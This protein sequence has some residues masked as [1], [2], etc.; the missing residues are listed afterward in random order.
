MQQQHV[1]HMPA[2][3]IRPIIHPGHEPRQDDELAAV[4]V[5]ISS[6]SSYDILFSSVP[7]MAGEG[8]RV[9]AYAASPDSLAHIAAALAGSSLQ[10]VPC[11]SDMHRNLRHLVSDIKNVTPDS[12]VFNW[13]C[14][15]GC[16]QDKFENPV[17]VMDLAKRLLDCGHMVM[18]SDFSLKALIASWDES[19]LGPNPFV[20]LGGFNTCFQLRYDT[21]KLAT[22]PSAQLQKLGELAAEGKA[23]V[24]AMG[25]TI[26][27]TV[28]WSKADCSAY[29]CEVLTVMTQADCSSTKD[30]VSPG[31]MCTV[32]SHQGV[33][34]HVL[35]KYPSGGRLL[36]SAGHWMELSKLDVSEKNLMQAAAF[37]GQGFEQEVKMAMGRCS[38]DAERKQTR[39]AYSCQMVQQSA[40]CSYSG[41]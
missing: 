8:K 16:C 35:L 1:V 21:A 30:R 5:T 23:D 11:S 4:I 2:A 13:E 18:F 34:G 41:F 22:C 10:G 19:K 29:I 6:G 9:A 31:M 25:D 38:T 15:S 26:L 17:V 37:Y 27:F 14:C 40:P 3:S 28:N 33:A 12:V 36:A 39:S 7:Q 20:K 32:D 24:S